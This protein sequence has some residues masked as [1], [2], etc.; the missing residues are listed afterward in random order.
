V[1]EDERDVTRSVGLKEGAGMTYK[2]EMMTKNWRRK[3]WG[4][5]RC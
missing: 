2:K 5:R 3:S 4:R 1:E